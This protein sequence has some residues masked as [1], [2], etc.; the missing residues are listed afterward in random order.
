MKK[1]YLVLAIF[2]LTI[3]SCNNKTADKINDME[4]DSSVTM[5]ATMMHRDSIHVMTETDSMNSNL[6]NNLDE[7]KTIKTTDPSEGKYSLS[8]TK[9]ILVQLNNKEVPRKEK[10]NYINLNSKMGT[11]SAYAG[12]NGINGSYVMEKSTN[13]IFSKISSTRM[14]CKD[15]SLENEFLQ[16][17]ENSQTYTI[18]ENELLLFNGKKQLAKFVIK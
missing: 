17:L 11:F 5:D 14:A 16:S 2:A 12:C 7:S 6:P 4:M 10:E 1:I 8:E 18:N 13:L 9:W 15:G 3:T